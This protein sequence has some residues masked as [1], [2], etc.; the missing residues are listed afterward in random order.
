MSL[1]NNLKTPMVLLVMSTGAFSGLNLCCFKFFGEILANNDFMNMPVMAS[2]LCIAGLIG[3]LTQILILN[4]AFR[5][6]NNIDVIPV[7]Q[8]LILSSML[9]HGWFLLDESQLYS[10][11][12][13]L[14][15]ICS[16][17]I[18]IIGI[19]I[20]TMKTT[21]IASLKKG[22]QIDDNFSEAATDIELDSNS[23]TL[24][25]EEDT[26]R[27]KYEQRIANVFRGVY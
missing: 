5:Y 4:V 22:G 2:A 27:A 19:K 12:Q 8:S 18:V 17:L 15:I 13:M 3:A 14:G 26:P 11:M 24:K 16:G 10:S 6:Y 21:V 1:K 20:I 7:L 9:I 23:D 25:K